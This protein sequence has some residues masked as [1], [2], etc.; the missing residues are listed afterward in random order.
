MEKNTPTLHSDDY[1]VM[2]RHLHAARTE[3]GLTQKQLADKLGI[4]QVLVSKIETCERR[5]D[6]IEL[7]NFCN[8]IG[9]PFVDF[10]A[11]LDAELMARH[12]KESN[13]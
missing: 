12:L 7:R 1:K 10:I 8:A 4:N 5:I 2:I 13:S 6:V 3:T 9:V 11:S